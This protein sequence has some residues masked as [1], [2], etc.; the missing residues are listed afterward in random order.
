[1]N[2]II[3]ITDLVLRT[4]LTPE[5]H[6]Y[7][8]MVRDS[9]ESLLGVI[10]DIL[11]FSKIEAGKL[12]LDVR[13]FDL[14][15]RLGDAV[16]SLGFRA[17]SK[18]LELICH[19]HPE[20]PKLLVGD[21]NRLRQIIV[22]LVGNAIKFTDCGEV[23]LETQ[24]IESDQDEVTLQFTVT[25]TG[26]GIPEAKLARIFDAFEQ[27]DTTT[28]RRFGGTGLG[29]SIST[30][31]IDL[32][33]GQIW[34]ESQV[35]RGSSFHFTAR[36]GVVQPQPESSEAD[37]TGVRGSKVLVVDDNATNRQ[38]LDEMLRNWQTRPML[39]A[40]GREAWEALHEACEARDPFQL[41][42]TDA[43]MPRMDGFDLARRIKQDPKLNSSVIMMLASSESPDEIARCER[44]GVDACLL[45]PI[46]QS[47][48]FNALADAIDNG[49][50]RTEARDERASSGP[51]CSSPKIRPLRILLAEDTLVNQK[52]AIGLLEGESHSVCVAND[53]VQ[54][55]EAIERERFDLVLM[56]V[57]MPEVDGLQ[58]TEQ[59]R[60]RERETGGHVPIVAM[61]AHAMEGDRERC[62]NAGMDDYIS[63]PIR[64][65]ELFATIERVVQAA[66]SRAESTSPDVA[67]REQ[68]AADDAL[69]WDEVLQTVQGDQVLLRVVIDT[70]LNECPDLLH[71][72]REACGAGDAKAVGRAAHA[73]KGAVGNFGESAAYRF[74]YELEQMGMDDN[75]T[76]MDEALAEVETQLQRLTSA[77][78]GFSAHAT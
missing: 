30:R 27:A 2:G 17:S 47:E 77:L 37:A 54:A 41:V 15:E 72:L 50:P 60:A 31:L 19:I 6:E 74:A 53:G 70:F 36:F 38:I 25:D 52:L 8:K 34:V 68:T 66:K 63:K 10:N 16:K 20:T 49:T 45:K 5:Q 61:T 55:L 71:R 39:V 26:V 51:E 21:A 13:E 76:Q 29:L 9:S 11:D 73:L 4:Q 69:D 57:Q 64:F 40:G 65:E 18:K 24:L 14:R 46:K 22:N 78:A 62:L 7:L 75:L 35:G 67:P 44:M 33:G 48:L 42:V 59:I 23:V 28:A 56:D 3:G 58:A 12:S 32:M 43:N 1:M